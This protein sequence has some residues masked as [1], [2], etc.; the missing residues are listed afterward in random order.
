VTVTND[1][2]LHFAKIVVTPMLSMLAYAC[3]GGGGGGGGS[4]APM[5]TYTIG[6]AVTGLSGSGLVLQNNAGTNLAVSSAGAFKFVGGL[7]SGAGYSVTVA[8]QPSAPT[9]FCEVTNGS[10][11]VGGAN[12]T[13]VAVT[14]TTASFTILANQP[15]EPGYLTLLLTDGSVMMQSINDASIF[16]DLVPAADGGYLNGTWHLLSSPPTGYAPADGAQAVLADGRVLFVGGEYNQNQYTL[17]FA[18][19]GLTNMSAVYDPV[20]DQWTMIAPPPGVAYI[21]DSP[22]AVM[23][24]GSFVFGTKLGRAM[25]RLDPVSLTWTSV[26]A[27]GKADDFAEEGW[28]LLPDGALLTIDV[29]DPPHAEHYDSAVGQWLSDGS[30][31]VIL[32]SPS[33]ITGGLTYGPAPVQVVGGVTYGPGPAGT[34]FP[35]GEIGPALLLPNGK[36]FATG[37]ALSGNTGHTAIYTPGAAPADPGSFTVGPDFAPGDDADDASAALLPSGHVLVAATSGQFYE[38][39]GT[40]MPVTGALPSNGGTM[41]YFVLPL[42]NGQALIT[43]GV[44]QVYS[45]AG[46]AD[47]AWAPTISAAPASVTRGTTYPISGTQFNG[48]SQG[49]D[50]GDE[51]N[52]ATNYPLVRITNVASSHVVYAR[53]HGHSSMG[54]ATGSTIVSTQFDVPSAAES[55]A[56][57]LVVVANGIASLPVSVTVN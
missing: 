57:T 51:L 13:S 5:V 27:A 32:A 23:P 16:Y 1:R 25:W 56:S 31:P 37:S 30:T 11:T 35:P 19:S 10:G 40:S 53:T 29:G 18:P 8:T 41:S 45:G 12:V 49:A 14:C 2:R 17:P 42:P 26:P 6:G 34:Y 39:D 20:A 48:L 24:D 3:G 22:S 47:A 54:V 38:Y 50:V 55:G 28:T 7:A 4:S 52:A 46:S 21:G 9:Q 43:G 36:V 33:D 44:T 15:P